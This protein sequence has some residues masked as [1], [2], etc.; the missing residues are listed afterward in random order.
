MTLAIVA[1]INFIIYFKFFLKKHMLVN[2][3]EDFLVDLWSKWS[4]VTIEVLS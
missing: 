3:I 4:L 1:L 2:W